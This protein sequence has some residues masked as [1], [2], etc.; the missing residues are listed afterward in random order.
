MRLVE[1]VLKKVKDDKHLTDQ[2]TQ[3]KAIRELVTA[4]NN[5]ALLPV[6]SRHRA[7]DNTTGLYTVG[8]ETYG[9][10]LKRYISYLPSADQLRLLNQYLT[11][12][13]HS[14]KGDVIHEDLDDIDAAIADAEDD[15]A[16]DPKPKV[17]E[18]EAAREERKLRHW[19]IKV[20]IYACL[21]FA[22]LVI[23]AMI[24]V[25]YHNHAM[26]DSAVFKTIMSTAV[27]LIKILSGSTK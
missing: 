5:V 24:A 3:S 13:P 8:G 2:I 11:H 10:D 19:A 18:S 4:Y 7:D 25:M 15:T 1:L 20:L 16:D 26:P 23:G 27:E 12:F 17:V 9:S 14:N 22:T 21:F 6:A